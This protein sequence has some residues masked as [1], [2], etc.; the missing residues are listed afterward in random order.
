VR[1][2]Y[3]TLITNISL[4]NSNPGKQQS[5]LIAINGAKKAGTLM[6]AAACTLI[7]KSNNILYVMSL[8]TALSCMNI[9]F[10]LICLTDR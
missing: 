3:T 6:L 5:M 7:L 1:D 4:D 10:A 2:P 8:V 9:I